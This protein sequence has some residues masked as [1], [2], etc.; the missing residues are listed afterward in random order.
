MREFSVRK[1]R[2]G[3]SWT[4]G[5]GG[6][7]E[8]GRRGG[9]IGLCGKVSVQPHHSVLFGARAGGG[10][11]LWSPLKRILSRP[12]FSSGPMCGDVK[13]STIAA[14]ISVSGR[15]CSC[16]SNRMLPIECHTFRA[17]QFRHIALPHRTEMLYQPT[18]P[19]CISVLSTITFLP[20]RQNKEAKT[21]ML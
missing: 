6:A 9:Y 8:Y 18:P 12:L 1:G 21:H 17:L 3:G 7:G 19:S 14:L 10:G 2:G 4:G 11:G 20:R 13:K 16:T 5:E 15:S